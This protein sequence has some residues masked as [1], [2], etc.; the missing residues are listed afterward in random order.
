SRTGRTFLS[1]ITECGVNRVDDCLVDI[2]IGV[3]DDSVFAAHLTNDPLQLALTFARFAGALPTL[4]PYFARSG[5]RDKIDIFVVDAARP[6]MLVTFFPKNVLSEP[7]SADQARVVRIKTTEIHRL[8]N[9]AV[10]FRPGFANF[11]DFQRRKFVTP[12]VHDISGALD[13]SA[14]R[15]K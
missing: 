13:Q 5:E 11:K 15:F 7:R 8:A 4:Q 12:A 14:A 10:R 6:V 3:D 9:V 1:L 2:G